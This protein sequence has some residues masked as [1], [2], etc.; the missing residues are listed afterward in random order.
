MQHYIEDFI[1]YLTIERGLSV[2]TTDSYKRDL[3]YFNQYL[4][5]S[6]ISFKKIDVISVRKYLNFLAKDKS[7]AS[8][9]RAVACLRSF[10]KFLLME[11]EIK[12]L[13]TQDLDSYKKPKKL[14]KV[15][16]QAEVERLLKQPKP[17]TPIGYRD[18]AMLEVLYG[19]GLRIS[20]LVG[21]TFD[22]ID[23]QNGFIRV[24]GKGSKQ[25]VIPIGSIALKALGDYSQKGWPKLASARISNVF[26]NARGRPITRQGCWQIV[27]KYADK[28]GVD[29]YPHSLRHSFATH[30]LENGADLRS[31]QE[32]LGH[33]SIS[34]TQIYTHVSNKYLKEVYFKY[35]PRAAKRSCRRGEG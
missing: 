17:V 1:N 12:N 26:L 21:L 9:A 16:G 19:A 18:K 11:G 32:M 29:I 20:E 2:N 22:D 8:V 31:V 15:F 35:H 30:L 25:R 7:P 14:P 5:K 28:A 6:N 33:S 10:Y 4:L 34:T 13:P 3:K 24:T 23:N 27:K